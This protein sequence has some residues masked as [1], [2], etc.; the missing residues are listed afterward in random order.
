MISLSIDGKQATVEEGTT[1]L[2]AA[3]SVGI[4]I[5]TLCYHR[6]LRPNSAC[7]LCTVEV[8]QGGRS[9]LTASCA[10]PAEDGMEVQT[11]TE[12]V[13]T[14][15][16]IVLELLVA[17]CGDVE[18]LKELAAGIGAKTDRLAAKEDNCI[19]CGLCVAV[20][21]QVMGARAIGFSGRGVDRKVT[22]PF[23]RKAVDCLACGAC[24]YLCPTGA[25]Q[26]EQQTL[27]HDKAEGA[28]RRCRYMRMGLIPYAI[29]P[30]SFDCATCEVDQRLED[31]LGT[32]P[33][34]VAHPAKQT[35]PV[36]V[37]GY[38]VMPDRYYHGGHVWVEK[39]GHHLRLG[40]DDFAQKLVGPIDN[41][42][43]LQQSGAEIKAGDD[44]WRL[45][46]G[47]G[48]SVT[49]PSP[50]SGTL[51]AVNED[52]AHDPTLL[53][54][55]PYTRGWICLL[56]PTQA[57]QELGELRFKDPSVPYYRREEPDPVHQ[58][59]DEDAQKLSGML[60]ENRGAAAMSDTDWQTVTQT[61]LGTH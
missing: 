51:L 45:E 39:V 7:R 36:D 59:L 6:E 28:L 55:A 14:G 23:G 9:R 4:D 24:V 56:R 10:L 8:T 21:S 20:C 46:L 35:D 5:P 38:A 32:H 30:A 34:F 16:R 25:M 58:W 43:P 54:K 1:V 33:A 18:A 44:L 37:G 52:I 29:C 42:V 48:K 50:V 26:M 3:R 15:R 17:R 49:M 2:E 60:G 31:A 12:Q 41:V 22:H 57:E 11:A 61:F 27:E 47:G 13:L 19:L 53:R 40:L